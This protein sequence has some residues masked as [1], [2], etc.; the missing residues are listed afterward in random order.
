MSDLCD[1]PVSLGNVVRSLGGTPVDAPTFQF[2]L[3][4]GDVRTAVPRL[5]SLGVGVRRIS[6]R[7]DY[8]PK[9]L[10]SHVQS[11][12]RLECYRPRKTE[13]HALTSTRSRSAH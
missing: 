10:A 4:R 1:D 2:E 11:I 6:E 9:G 8:D 7:R 3:P 13:P 12:V 5:N